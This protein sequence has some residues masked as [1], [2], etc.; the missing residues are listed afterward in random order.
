MTRTTEPG[1]TRIASTWNRQISPDTLRAASQGALN[2]RERDLFDL[3]HP[4]AHSAGKDQCRHVLRVCVISKP[5]DVSKRLDSECMGG[6]QDQSYTQQIEKIT[7]NR[8]LEE[9][10]KEISRHLNSRNMPSNC[11]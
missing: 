8:K 5:L 7:Q 9:K 3:S 11:S 10:I 4:T 6:T 2:C 1:R